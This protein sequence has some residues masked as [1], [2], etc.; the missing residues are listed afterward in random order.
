M[1]TKLE[2]IEFLETN[3]IR[4]DDKVVVHS[5]LR[6]VGPIE[7]NADGL[8]DAMCSYLSEGFLYVLAIAQ[9]AQ[10]VCL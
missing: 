1:I 2:I 9:L 3:G 6:S 8:I 10:H 5:S 4:H 7:D